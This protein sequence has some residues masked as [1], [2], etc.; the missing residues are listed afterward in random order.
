[1]S[2]HATRARRH[3]HRCRDDHRCWS[4]RLRDQPASHWRRHRHHHQR[5][6]LSAQD[7]SGQHRVTCKCRAG[8][9]H[10][11]S[12]PT[13]VVMRACCCPCATPAPARSISACVCYRS[14]RT[15]TPRT[16]LLQPRMQLYSPSVRY[17]RPGKWR[18][19]RPAHRRAHMC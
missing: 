8:F 13:P 18:A 2:R 12:V 4:R 7:R 14:R 11:T 1:V 16:R 17:F 15:L 6:C 5:R 9:W 19:T 10:R 3:C